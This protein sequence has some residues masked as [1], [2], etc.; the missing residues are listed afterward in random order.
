MIAYT[1]GFVA[2]T[3]PAHSSKVREM[4]PRGFYSAAE[5]GRL[6][7]VSG[8]TIGQWKRWN[9]I[10]ASREDAA[11]PHVYAYQDIGEAMIAHALVN[12]NVPR[13]EIRQAVQALRDAYGYDWPLS[14]ADLVVTDYGRR[15]GRQ[16]VRG[17][18]VREGADTYLDL[19]QHKYPWQYV[20]SPEH[21]AQVALEL[22]RGGWAA[23]EMPELQHIEV[24]P[25]RLSGRPV[26]RGTRVLADQTARM[27][28][29]GQRDDLIEG[30]ELT[31]V[32]INDA[33]KWFNRVV[34]YEAA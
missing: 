12:E 17:L 1:L 10:R 30:Y 31:D 11:Y 2:D 23:R 19:T 3:S 14:Q 28:L 13:R 24:D 33:V 20:I 32:Q 18:V 25:D 5:V 22:N 27:A 8:N 16:E 21:V 6:A 15:E 26:I 29:A 4:P 34:E 9:Y 7:G